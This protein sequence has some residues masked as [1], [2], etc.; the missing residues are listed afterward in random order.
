MK[1][2][3]KVAIQITNDELNASTIGSPPTLNSCDDKFNIGLSF[4]K[5]LASDSL[6]LRRFLKKFP[7]ERSQVSLLLMV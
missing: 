6:P 2:D 3:F 7:S 5:S 4:T 1:T